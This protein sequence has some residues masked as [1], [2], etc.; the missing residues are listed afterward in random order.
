M[1]EQD[2]KPLELLI[3]GQYSLAKDSYQELHKKNPSLLS[4]RGNSLGILASHVRA[5]HNTPKLYEQ[6][7]E[8]AIALYGEKIVSWDADAID[9]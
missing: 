3:S 6:L 8:I 4:I 7:R 9:I 1:K 2:L 5:R